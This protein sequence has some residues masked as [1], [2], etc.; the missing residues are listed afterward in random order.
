MKEIVIDEPRGQE[1][2]NENKERKMP[3]ELSE[4]SPDTNP[5]TATN[6]QANLSTLPWGSGIKLFHCNRHESVVSGG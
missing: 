3:T 4:R 6:E 1:D 5:K 2:E